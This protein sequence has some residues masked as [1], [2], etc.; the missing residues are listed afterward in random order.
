MRFRI[1][2]PLEVEAEDG[3]IDLGTRKQR[4]LFAL[5]LIN[6]NRV[7]STDRILDELWGEDAEGKENALW[8]YVSRLRAALG[9]ASQ[10]PM[11][12]TKDRGYSLV[13]DPELLDAHEFE[14]L[15]RRGSSRLRSDPGAAATDLSNALDLWK[16]HALEE[17][18]YDDFAS[19]EIARLE[20]L[21][22]T[23]VENR[24]DADL[25]RGL[26][27]E[28]IGELERL[29]AERR[30]DER[31]VGQLMLAQYRA[32]RQADALRC[33]ERFRRGIGEELGLDPS[34]ELRRLEEQIL[35]HDSRLQPRTPERTAGLAGAFA[36]GRN[37][38]RGLEAFREEDANVFFGRDHLV[39]D[40]LKRFDKHPIVSLVGSSGCGKSSAVRSGVIPAVRKGAIPGSDSW[41]IAQMVPGSNP[42]AELEAALLRASFDAPNSLRE[43]LDG[44]PDEIL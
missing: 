10:E 36:H 19:F 26:S 15:V 30:L 31:P 24:I 33:F 43:Q 6:H 9:D 41:L 29:V 34:P 3:L 42:F 11:L 18:V 25:K 37:P 4:S 2:G 22:K 17:F 38:F 28:L 5:L 44:S 20:E 40:I 13:I 16:G 27:G 12:I 21:H 39:S 1:L 23:C 32:G 14:D 7:V 8:V 35:L